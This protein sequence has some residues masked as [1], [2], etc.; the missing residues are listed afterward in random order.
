MS[1][2]S[3]AAPQSDL[4]TRFAAAVPI[5][6]ARLHAAVADEGLFVENP[7]RVRQHY[8]RL[9]GAILGAGLVLMFVAGITLAWAAGAVWLPGAAMVRG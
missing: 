1:E 8:A 7:A 4:L 3:P 6:Q 9:G 5:L 2:K